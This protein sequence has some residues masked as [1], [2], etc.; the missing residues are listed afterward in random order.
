ML[1]GRLFARA[2]LPLSVVLCSATAYADNLQVC[3]DAYTKAQEERLAGHSFSA[4][5]QLQVCAQSICP[6]TVVHD[7]S[8]WL[9]EVETTLPTIVVSAKDS[10]GHPVPHLEVFLDGVSIPAQ[11]LT[12]PIFL[13]VGAHNLRFEAPGYESVQLNPFLRAGDRDLQV[14]AAL[15]VN[16]AAPPPPV[17]ADAGTPSVSR[18]GRSASAP[19]IVFAAV[20]TVALGGAIYFG[21]SAS[22][23]Y[24]ELKSQCD[25]HCTQSQADSVHNKQLIADIALA[26]SVVAFGAA[27][28]FYFSAEPA[29]AGA[30]ALGLAPTPDGA[31]AQLRVAF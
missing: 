26:T 12:Q 2:L 8:Q 24:N 19:A 30:T 17:G 27:A 5:L 10:V 18:A 31:R 22:S 6:E 3:S 23:R 15:L 9:T 14:S 21:L 4:R 1:F 20:G 29:H 16:R 7:C 11:Q 13:D 25:T 28:W